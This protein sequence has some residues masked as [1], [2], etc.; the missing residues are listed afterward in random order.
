MKIKLDNHYKKLLSDISSIEVF[1]KNGNKLDGKYS[2][3]IT[4][5]PREEVFDKKRK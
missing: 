4:G 3:I 1:D 5:I 2:N